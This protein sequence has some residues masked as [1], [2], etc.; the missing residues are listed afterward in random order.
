LKS[1][2][3]FII[4]CFFFL[5]ASA[6]GKRIQI[7]HSDNSSIDELRLPG[8][9]IL[10]GNIVI[11]HEGIKLNCK[12]AIH[13]KNEN[14][15]KAY[16]DVVLNQ[17]DS[18]IQTSQYTEYNGN[19]QKA[20]SWG[21]VVIKDAK[22]TLSTDTLNFDRSRQ[23]LYY[24]YGATIK[25][26]VNVLTSDTGNY[27]LENNKFQA[28]SDVV[29]T[30][31]DY[32]LESNHL[33]YYTDS[34]RAFLYGASTIRSDDNLI[35]SEKGFYDTQQNISHFTRNA[36]IE[37]D[38]KEIKADSL[39]YNRNLG[40]ASATKNI[41]ITDTVNHTVLKGNYAEFFE[42]VDSAFVV[43]KAVAITN[44][45]K[46]SLFIHGDTILATGK[47][48]KRIIRAYHH[49]KFFK[50]DLSG[51][52]DSIHSD[53]GSGLTQMF[54]SPVLWSNKSQITGDT[55]QML[56]NTKTNKLDSLKVLRNAFIIDKD[57]IGFNQIKGRDLYGK[58]EEND[59]RFVNIV[60]NSEVIHFVRDDNQ[61]LIGIE[62]T[63]CSEIHFV[64]RDGKIEASKFITSPDG[65]TYPPSKLPQN[66]RKL[67]G[68]I[69]R[70][71]EKPL[72]KNDI[73]IK[74]EE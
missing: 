29:L 50:S 52:C 64:L 2:F 61:A 37:Y 25:D 44:T 73:F 55:I 7:I 74:D 42:K 63:S 30:N 41:V 13:Y 58:F 68:F 65:Q 21:N 1:T 53:Q 23:L 26:S 45:N 3:F 15:I 43:K 36:R 54:R 16:G 8:A 57:S 39:F 67:R 38:N 5:T 71:A 14:F 59:L 34:R 18:I 48:E 33:D 47:P 20:L 49:V 60:G 62:K 66:A 17:G 70:E 6:Q 72:S 27:Y 28:I 19:T 51:K 46:D 22:M 10:L 69:W 9:T 12:K 4:C 32:V 11:R 31:P 24:K 35:Y 56:N 40:F